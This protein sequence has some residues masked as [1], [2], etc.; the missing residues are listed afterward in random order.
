MKHFLLVA[1]LFAIMCGGDFL[2][3]GSRAVASFHYVPQ[4][5]NIGFACVVVGA[6]C[7]LIYSEKSA[8]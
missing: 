5:D 6:V 1:G 4:S 2:H 8:A 3:I 7:I